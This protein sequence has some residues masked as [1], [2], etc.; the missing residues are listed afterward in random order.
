[1]VPAK[2]NKPLARHWIPGAPSLQDLPPLIWSTRNCKDEWAK[3]ESA[4]VNKIKS[5]R[6]ET[7][8]T[9]IRNL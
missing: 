6:E 1:M 5:A 7:T 2:H 3:A 9:E 8:A 4:M